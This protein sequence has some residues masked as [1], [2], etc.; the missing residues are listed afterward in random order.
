MT[1]IVHTDPAPTLDDVWRLFKEMALETERRSQESKREFQE[2]RQLMQEQRQEADRRSREADR[3]SQETERVLKEQM[4]NLNTQLGNLG[5]RIGEFVEEQVM[6]SALALIQARGIAVH[7]VQRRVNAKRKGQTTEIDLLLVNDTDIVAVEVK[8]ALSV[9][10]VDQHIKRLN[11]FKVLFPRY[12]NMQVYGAVAGMVVPDDA[13]ERGLE[14]GLFVLVPSADIM[15]L[16]SEFRH[17]FTP[18]LTS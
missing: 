11:N 5:N 9:A 18:I 10:Y 2:I 1:T 15:Q 6:P 16:A 17:W 3:R 14:Q 4:K 7:E 13:K 8:S 12:A